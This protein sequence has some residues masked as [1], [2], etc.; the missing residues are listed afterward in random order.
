VI[1]YLPPAA[2]LIFKVLASDGPLTQ[3]DII[4]RTDLPRRKVRYALGKLMEEDVIRESFSLADA[5]QSLYGLSDL[6]FKTGRK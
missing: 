3:K 1:E 2:K 5:R 6:A 4:S